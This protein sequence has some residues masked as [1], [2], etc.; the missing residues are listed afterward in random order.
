M[1]TMHELAYDEIG[2]RIRKERL[3]QSLSQEKLAEK[4]DISTSFMG[5]IE[6]GTKKM[7]VDTLVRIAYELNLSTDYLL[8][9]ELPPSDEN[10]LA[11][12]N[13][14]KKANRNQYE[15]YISIIKTL[16]EISDTL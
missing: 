13:T 3:K 1:T 4:C 8:M 7:S 10:I 16:A 6:R 12:I 11:I 5:H 2:I 14:V 9:D 15:R